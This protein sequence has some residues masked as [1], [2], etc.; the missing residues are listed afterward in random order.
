MSGRTDLCYQEASE[1]AHLKTHS[2]QLV[3]SLFKERPLLYLEVPEIVLVVFWM[4]R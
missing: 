4:K 1:L 3:L 2:P